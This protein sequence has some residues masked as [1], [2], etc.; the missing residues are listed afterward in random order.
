MIYLVCNRRSDSA[1]DLAAALGA[2]II[3]VT[4]PDTYTV[5]WGTRQT[6]IINSRTTRDKLAELS[7]LKMHNVPVPP[8]A[9]NPAE[10]Q[11]PIGRW[12]DHKHGND[13]F[14]AGR[15]GRERADYFVER[16]HTTHEFRLHLWKKNVVRASLKVK[17][18]PDAHPWIRT[19]NRGWKF[20][21][22]RQ[23]QEVLSDAVRDTARAA[24]AAVKLTFGAVDLAITSTGGVVVFEVNSAPG[25]CSNTIERY[26]PYFRKDYETWR[27]RR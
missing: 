26:V 3:P 16:V 15:H 13:L 1:R 4:R 21:Y 11:M 22:G 12:N 5:N 7:V 19:H 24:L 23:C 25:M 10:L 2:E 14:R 20:D 9:V 8:F 18:R 17:E 27:R 6:C